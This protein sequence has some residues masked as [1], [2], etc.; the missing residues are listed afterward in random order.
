MT[1]REFAKEK[2]RVNRLFR[3][4]IDRLGYWS[5]WDFAFTYTDTAWEPQEDLNRAVEMEITSSAMYQYAH[6]MVN[7]EVTSQR[8]NKDLELSI[9]HELQHPTLEAMHYW[10]EDNRFTEEYTA[11][12]LAKRF[13][14]TFEAGRKSARKRGKTTP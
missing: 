8:S 5:G 12:I 13:I 11:T 4:W 9:V 3:L 10:K 6:I 1:K 2:A 7:C 14:H